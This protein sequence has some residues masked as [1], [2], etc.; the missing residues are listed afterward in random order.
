MAHIYAE[1]KPRLSWQVNPDWPRIVQGSRFLIRSALRPQSLQ[2]LVHGFRVQF[3]VFRDFIRAHS[4]EPRPAHSSRPLPNAA[5]S[6][7]FMDSGIG[8]D[9]GFCL[10]LYFPFFAIWKE[11]EEDS[12]GT[13][14]TGTDSQR[15]PIEG[16]P[17]PKVCHG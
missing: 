12:K 10:P 15:P 17:M 6:E 7:G 4:V 5:V 16:N 1:S 9:V 13:T 11:P 14:K 2:T 3:E 8:L